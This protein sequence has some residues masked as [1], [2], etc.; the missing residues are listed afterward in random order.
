MLFSFEV[1]YLLMLFH[2]LNLHITG[3]MSAMSFL[4]TWRAISWPLTL[5]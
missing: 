2:I 1:Q 5:H 4:K 3:A